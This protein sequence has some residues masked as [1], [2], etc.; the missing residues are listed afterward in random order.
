MACSSASE[1]L[2]GHFNIIKKHVAEIMLTVATSVLTQNP[3]LTC[4]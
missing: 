4:L 2:T 1:F 3:V